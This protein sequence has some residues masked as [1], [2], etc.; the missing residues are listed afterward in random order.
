MSNTK[1]YLLFHSLSYFEKKPK[2]IKTKHK[3][4]KL[5]SFSKTFQM[6]SFYCNCLNVDET[7]KHNFVSHRTNECE[8]FCQ[9][10]LKEEQLTTSPKKLSIFPSKGVQSSTSLKLNLLLGTLLPAGEAEQKLALIR[11]LEVPGK[12]G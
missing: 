10:H 5:Y 7:G 11:Y 12:R 4:H 6:T 8:D 1:Q 2:N 3:T 9:N